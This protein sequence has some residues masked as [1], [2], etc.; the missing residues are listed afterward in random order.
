MRHSLATSAFMLT[1]VLARAAAAEEPAAVESAA[2]NWQRLAGAE[3]CPSGA[4]V[5]L[6]I[7]Q[8]LGHVALVPKAQATLTI[9]AMLEGS[10]SGGF[11]VEITLSR[12]DVVVGK[13]EL[14]SAEPSC[15]RIAE[16]AA[17]VIALAIDPEASLDP[18]PIPTAPEPAPASPVPPPQPA[19]AHTESPS[20]PRPAI[21]ARKKRW[22][23]DLE[24]GG[25]LLIDAAPDLASA[26]YV[27]GRV[28]PPKWP[29]GIELGAAYFPT[30][31]V[32]ALPGKGA[33]FSTYLWAAG[34]CSR[35]IR[36][37]RFSVSGCASG[38]AGQIS[39][40]GYGFQSTETF[41]TLT[42]A[43]AARGALWY[44]FVTPL[45]LVLGSTVAVPLKRDYFEVETA[46]GT[47]PLFRMSA[48]G[49]GFNLGMVL[50]F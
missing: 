24:L 35:P 10:S 48:I 27:R 12:G 49:L 4:E 34:V 28:L 45:A 38:E 16:T 11:H 14:E 3:S 6:A 46:D 5:S 30:R 50:E 33:Y 17:L 7:E 31:Q 42:V 21:L 36:S 40:H 13:R 18:L 25:T 1:A 20:E 26:I 47:Q 2:L 23:G 41:R 19:I 32:E 39:G 15:Q 9:D 43:L 22:Q 44:R 37:S 8:R 29:L